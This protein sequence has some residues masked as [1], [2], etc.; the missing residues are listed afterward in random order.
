M[1]R[2]QGGA[3][4]YVS[5]RPTG[6]SVFLTFDAAG[7]IKLTQRAKGESARMGRAAERAHE[8][9]AKEL[10]KDIAEV[11]EQKVA[12]RGRVQGM[13]RRGRGG[14]K[15]ASSRLG[16][17]IKSPQNRRVNQ[18][19]YTV[20]YLDEI[21]AVAPYY[22]NL[23]VGTSAHVGRYLSG[24]FLP[25]GPGQMK[26]GQYAGRNER[27]AIGRDG[28]FTQAAFNYERPYFPGVKIKN[29]IVGYRYF[30]GGRRQFIGRGGTR[31]M[32]VRAYA[33]AFKAEGIDLISR[34]M[35][36]SVVA[37]VPSRST[38]SAD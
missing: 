7:M 31:N 19:G 16:N 14:T 9:L 34:A 8:V 38:Y 22:R 24:V 36:G 33:D 17:A 29:A 4:K 25:G 3:G 21:E 32:A 1:P 2:Y 18:Q 35:D 5:A 6:G 30:E 27:R 28:R 26:R 37:S 15:S 23:E 10:Q 13:S 20:G 11:L 12:A